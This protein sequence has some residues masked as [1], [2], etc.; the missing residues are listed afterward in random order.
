MRRPED[1]AEGDSVARLPYLKNLYIRAFSTL[2]S[3][4]L[5]AHLS[6]SQHVAL[7]IH[8]DSDDLRGGQLFEAI[9]LMTRSL[10]ANR[11]VQF[12]CAQVSF[13][14]DVHC[15]FWPF[16]G[17]NGFTPGA[18]DS[19]ASSLHVYTPHIPYEFSCHPSVWYENL[20]LEH[21]KVLR[22]HQGTLKKSPIKDLRRY[23]QRMKQLEAL[24]VID[25]VAEYLLPQLA[26]RKRSGQG[27][28]P[29]LFESVKRLKVHLRVTYRPSYLDHDD[30]IEGAATRIPLVV[31]ALACFL[32]ER[33]QEGNAI[34]ELHIHAP[35]FLLS[36]DEFSQEFEPLVGRAV[37]ECS[38]LITPRALLTRDRRTLPE[39]VP[40]TPIG[41]HLFYLEDHTVH[42]TVFHQRY[43]GIYFSVSSTIA[44]VMFC[45]LSP[46]CAATGGTLRWA[47]RVYGASPTAVIPIS[48]RLSYSTAITCAFIL[49]FKLF[50]STMIS[51]RTSPG[52]WN[53]PTRERSMKLVDILQDT[54]MLRK[55]TLCSDGLIPCDDVG[56]FTVKTDKLLV[57]RLPHLEEFYMSS[58]TASTCMHVLSHLI[59]DQPV[60]LVLKCDLQNI[61]P[62]RAPSAMNL[63]SRFLTA[64]RQIVHRFAEIHAHNDSDDRD[65]SPSHFCFHDSGRCY[66]QYWHH[67]LPLGDVQTLLVHEDMFPHRDL[68][69][70]WEIRGLPEKFTSLQQVERLEIV[71]AVA[72]YLIPHFATTARS[73]DPTHPALF[74][75]LKSFRLYFHETRRSWCAPE[76]IPALCEDVFGV[77]ESYLRERHEEGHPIEELG[78]HAPSGI[79]QSD[80]LDASSLLSIRARSL[81]GRVALHR[82]RLTLLFL[83]V[84]VAGSSDAEDRDLALGESCVL[85]QVELVNRFR[86]HADTSTT[87]LPR[88]AGGTNQEGTRPP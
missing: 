82:A 42:S 83:L 80:E 86:Q 66:P 31:D 81:A 39:G 8:N 34:E 52:E 73:T 49:S 40:L 6:F 57:A 13:I 85:H 56:D 7:H 1:T 47:I 28:H 65:P 75:R 30:M 50:Q 76:N 18:H 62:D 54:P 32:S 17:A 63:V 64:N 26:T 67:Y 10:T 16:V 48:S 71:A 68:P 14:D 74:P 27:D 21:V 4:H 43:S 84:C 61:L 23:F 22:V 46:T 29:A 51:P 19:S 24:D 33:Q 69:K 5:L 72:W 70:G 55:L 87:F 77:L 53:H 79:I 20:P 2:G 25:E 15:A 44:T 59:I 45:S 38:L 41:F 12:L 3:A 78:I 9:D 58:Y 88:P 11:T 37:L 35:S 60:T 36:Q